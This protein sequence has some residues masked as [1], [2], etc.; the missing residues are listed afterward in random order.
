MTR[1]KTQLRARDVALWQG[2]FN[3]LGGAWPLVSLRSFEWVYGDKTDVFLQKTV[4]GLLLSI[5]YVQL[6]ADDSAEGNALARRLGIATALTLLL[7]DL[8]YIPRGQMRKTYIQD[9]LCEIGW[10]A[11]WAKAGR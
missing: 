4:G 11:A 3:V 1:R 9:A 6:S 8:V 2:V 7:V 5:G 10:L